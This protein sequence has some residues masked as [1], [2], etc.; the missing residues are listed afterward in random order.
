[1]IAPVFQSAD[2]FPPYVHA[3]LIYLLG[4]SAALHLY[5]GARIMRR[6]PAEGWGPVRSA[7]GGFGAV[8]AGGHA[9]AAPRQTADVGYAGLDRPAVPGLVLVAVRPDGAARH[10]ASAGL[11]REPDRAAEPAH[12]EPAHPH[13]RRRAPAGHSGDLHRLPERAANGPGEDGGDSA[14]RAAGGT[15]RLHHRADQRRPRRPDHPGALRGRH[16]GSASTGSSRT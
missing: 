7:A 11:G 15:A 10:P 13:G 9:L 12:R 14:G 4:L 6:C 8:G 5:I 3:P 16:R 1:M 2:P